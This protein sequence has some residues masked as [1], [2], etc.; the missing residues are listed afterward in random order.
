MTDEVEA[1][2]SFIFNVRQPMVIDKSKERRTKSTSNGETE[3][4]ASKIPNK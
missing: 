2:L 3:E 4:R 1:Q